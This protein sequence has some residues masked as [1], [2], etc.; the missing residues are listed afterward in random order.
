M[1]DL[2][3]LN[4][5]KIFF[6]AV[7]TGFAIN[8][9]PDDRC[10]SFYSDRSRHGLYCSIVG[11]VVIPE[12]NGS[13]DVCAQIS[14]KSEWTLLAKAIKSQG[15]KAGIQ[16]SSTW[17][18]YSGMKKFMPANHLD[19][20]KFYR[21]QS[22]NIDEKLI[23]KSFSKLG[24]ATDLAIS[25]GFEHI[26]LHAAH[27]YLFNLMLDPRFS[28]HW[29]LGVDYFN[30]WSKKLS[31][32]GAESSIRIS[33]RTGDKEIDENSDPSLFENIFLSNVDYI[34][35]SEGFYNINK[36]LIYPSTENILLERKRITLDV[37]AKYPRKLIIASG[38]AAH[39]FDSS[40][41][42][43]IHIGLCRDLICNP[44]FLQNQSIKC[45]Y[46]MK[47][48]YFSRGQDYIDCEKWS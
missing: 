19:A 35:I 25:H 43:N 29:K 10:I 16:F 18:S 38:R 9:T 13:N 15:A 2:I 14:Q 1:N 40:T 42:A 47:C 26:Q 17:K 3:A 5:R 37:A 31:Q 22:A 7:N 44:N 39:Y 32:I 46:C 21:E 27:G 23:E 12:G 11:N 24:V 6:L 41:P 45:E 20:V 4:D 8:G 36:R 28:P 48:H 34:D 30:D 33:M